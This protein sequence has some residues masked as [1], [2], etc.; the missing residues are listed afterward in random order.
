[1]P[2]LAAAAALPPTVARPMGA[3]PVKNLRSAGP[4]GGRTSLGIRSTAAAQ[5]TVTPAPGNEGLRD[6]V[7]E[8]LAFRL[9][10]AGVARGLLPPQPGAPAEWSPCRERAPSSGRA[11]RGSNTASSPLHA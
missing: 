3:R 6:P 9:P 2:S 1:M 8:P 11:R 5:A 4:V 10:S 7:L